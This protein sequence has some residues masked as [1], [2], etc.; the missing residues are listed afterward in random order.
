MRLNVNLATI[1]YKDVPRFLRRWGLVTLLLMLGTAALIWHTYSSWRDT[2]EVNQKIAQMHTEI[3]QAQQERAAAIEMLQ[4][5][6]NRDI[7]AQSNYIN[8]LIVRKAFSWTRVFM[9]L[10][11]IMPAHL[12]VNL[13]QPELS[14]TTHQLLLHMTVA[15]SSR[16]QAE[17]LVRRLETSPQFRHAQ[18]RSETMTEDPKQIDDK[19]TFDI[20]ADYVPLAAPPEAAAPELEKVKNEPKPVAAG[21]AVR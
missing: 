6:S 14:P 10:E 1:P 3:R 16:D 11:K 20:S 19:I 18:L 8:D 5:S 7:V 13:I 4:R 9:T 12:H 21:K 17:E 2:R 15:G